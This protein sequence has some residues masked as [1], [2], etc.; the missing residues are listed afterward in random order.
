MERSLILIKNTKEVRN[1][2][3]PKL[4]VIT[5]GS[6]SGKTHLLNNWHFIEQDYS[7]VKKITTR[8]P[9]KAEQPETN[10]E[11]IFS[12]SR[13][14]VEKCNFIYSYRDELYGFLLCDIEEIHSRGKNAII[15]IKSIDVIMQ[16]KERYKKLISI[17]CVSN[18]EID[19]LESY[20]ESK[21]NPEG[22]NKKRL[23]NKDDEIYKTEYSK[24]S[25]I[26]DKIIYNSYDESFLLE[27]KMFIN[28]YGK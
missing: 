8:S 18:L 11:F 15:I 10:K 9:R 14:E 4:I 6:G 16:L 28:S 24:F 23:Y 13:K 17:L 1:I 21:G 25:Y 20:L 3:T 5:G 22:E 26:F 2:I 27:I 12:C 7:I 19:K